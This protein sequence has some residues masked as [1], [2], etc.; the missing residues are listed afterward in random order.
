MFTT[1]L[2]SALTCLALEFLPVRDYV[3]R[4]PPKVEVDSKQ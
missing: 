3:H 4:I 1:M 2:I